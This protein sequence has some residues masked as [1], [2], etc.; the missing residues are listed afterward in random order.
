M[1]D[2][3]DI[4]RGYAA[5]AAGDLET[6]AG[7][8]APDVVWHVPGRSSLAGTRRGTH[9][10]LGYFGQLFE[11]SGGTFAAELKQCGEL[12][13]G[14]VACLVRITA[15]MP[16][17][18]VDQQVVQLFKRAHGLT[19]EVSTYASDQYQIDEAEVESQIARTKRAYGAFAAG[20]LDTI[21]GML[22]PDIT[23]TVGGRSALAGTY[24]GTVSVL[25]YF[26]ALFD[27]SGGTFKADLVDC[28]DLSSDTVAARVHITAQLPGGPLDTTMIQVFREQDGRAIEVHG[29]VEDAY[30]IDDAW[31]ATTISLPDARTP[32]TERVRS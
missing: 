26:A 23:W 11:I 2:V 19:T 21:A 3:E 4:R 6:I 7:L 16:G 9:A 24:R 12:A 20:D 13:H 15:D 30:A 32:S 29:Y 25:G 1:N 27:R 17:G 31:G 14:L 28:G 8:L 18:R 5:F 10:V 22:H